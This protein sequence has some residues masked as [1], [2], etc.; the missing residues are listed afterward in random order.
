MPKQ[1]KYKKISSTMTK[2]KNPTLPQ[3]TNTEISS[4][5]TQSKTNLLNHPAKRKIFIGGKKTGKTRGTGLKMISLL[6]SNKDAYGLALKKYSGNATKRLHT[7]YSNLAIKLSRKYNIPEF[8]KSTDRTYILHNKSL[9][10]ISKNQSIEYASFENVSG[11][12]GIEAPNAGYF[13]L[14]H[15]EEPVE[16]ND[17]GKIPTQEEWDMAMDMVK[18]SVER[19]NEEYN[20]FNLSINNAFIP[21]PEPEYHFTMNA[22]D[23]HPLIQEA[24]EHFPESEFLEWVKQD[25]INNNIDHR[26]DES[27]DTLYVRMT[28][29]AN[30]IEAKK[31]ELIKLA[32]QALDEDD[33]AKLA[34]IFG[35]KY[36]GV[37]NK[38]KTYDTTNLTYS[39]LEEATKNGFTTTAFSMGWDVD[40][41]RKLVGTPTF[42]MSKEILG[43]KKYIIVVGEQEIIVGKVKRGTRIPS[44]DYAKL[45]AEITFSYTD[46]LRT[47]DVMLF[48]DE[49]QAFVDMVES[50][51][52]QFNYYTHVQKAVKKGKDNHWNIL[53]RQAW[54]QTAIDS[55]NFYMDERNT[56]L[57]QEIESSYKK[58]GQEKRDE[59]GSAEKHYDY[60]NSMEYS[61]YPFAEALERKEN[62]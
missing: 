5:L 57:L 34:L 16:P 35:M 33:N 2:P 19:A 37:S 29:F 59:S 14:V 27:T 8:K 17:S 46:K 1:S 53:E 6:M 56:E 13:A 41:R 48:I 23:D 31:P 12:A 20:E 26:Y 50:E 42:L 15:I 55:S 49:G 32:Q 10:H 7:N 11:L 44:Q 40:F 22:W 45:I 62:G 58:L 51:M 4:W 9:A 3:F 24:E 30:P 21:V 38:T 36:E 61:V 47:K 28:K 39:T 52:D 54:L 60:L 43:R 18:D 25:F